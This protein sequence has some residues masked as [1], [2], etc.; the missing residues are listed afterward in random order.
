MVTSLG[1]LAPPLRPWN[2]WEVVGAAVI[3][4]Q[5]SSSCSFTN[6]LIIINKIGLK[7]KIWDFE[8]CFL[9]FVKCAMKAMRGRGWKLYAF[10]WLCHSRPK[11][12]SSQLFHTH[13]QTHGEKY[14]VCRTSFTLSK[15]L[16]HVLLRH[17]RYVHLTVTHPAGL[18]DLR[19][20][21]PPRLALK[22]NLLKLQTDNK[23]TVKQIPNHWKTI[24]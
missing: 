9:Q 6:G 13:I 14:K 5:V 16:C 15:L 1:T 19:F 24:I 23:T 18:M 22:H 10:C 11:L 8:G 4:N 7:A 2:V 12:V 21:F 3:P 20:I 17:G